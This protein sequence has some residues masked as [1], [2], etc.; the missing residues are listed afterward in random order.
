MGIVSVAE[1]EYTRRFE[2]H[3]AAVAA[4]DKTHRRLGW[5]RLLVLIL[6]IGLAVAVFDRGVSAGWLLLA[7]GLLFAGL[8]I[9]HQTVEVRLVVIWRLTIMSS[10]PIW[11]S[12]VRALSL[13][14]SAAR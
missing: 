4:T 1:Q 14:S 3:R 7:M 6:V 12:L 5:S 10:H 2:H 13:S 9:W 11:A 8:T